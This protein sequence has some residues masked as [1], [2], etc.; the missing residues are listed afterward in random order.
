[1]RHYYEQHRDTYVYAIRLRQLAERR[2][3]RGDLLFLSLRRRIALAELVRQTP[4]W[5]WPR[6]ARAFGG[7]ATYLAEQWRQQQRDDRR[8][9]DAVDRARDAYWSD[10]EPQQSLLGIAPPRA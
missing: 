10:H 3:T 4:G 5:T 9:V 2:Q 1:M 7:N 6:R 8:D